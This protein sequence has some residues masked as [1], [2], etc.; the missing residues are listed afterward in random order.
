VAG[1]RENYQGKLL[2]G[3]DSKM[4]GKLN[5]GAL[6]RKPFHSVDFRAAVR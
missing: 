4:N 1:V 3:N 6:R 5:F 2:I